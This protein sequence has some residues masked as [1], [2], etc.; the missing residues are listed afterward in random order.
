MFL[1]DKIRMKFNNANE[2]VAGSYQARLSTLNTTEY[3]VFMLLRE[4]F[5]KKECAQRLNMKRRAANN[6][7]RTILHKLY[8]R[9]TA[10]LI[11]KYREES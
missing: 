5:S 6:Y 11:V 3:K 10:E 2:S 1:L 8:V 7:I 9:N 4:G